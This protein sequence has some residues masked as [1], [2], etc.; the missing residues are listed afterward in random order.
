MV[1]TLAVDDV[2]D[3]QVNSHA[4]TPSAVRPH[5]SQEFPDIKHAI[6]NSS[7]IHTESHPHLEYESRQTHRNPTQHDR[8]RRPAAEALNLST[9]RPFNTVHTCPA[10]STLATRTRPTQIDYLG[11][12]TF[13]DAIIDT[14]P[15]TCSSAHVQIHEKRPRVSG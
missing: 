10:I 5:S 2:S 6:A 8:V 13:E 14:R 9:L 15:S 3:N 7:R 4:M 1:V 12:M 11:D